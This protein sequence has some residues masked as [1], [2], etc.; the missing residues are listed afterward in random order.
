MVDK[1]GDKLLKIIRKAV[2][3]ASII[4]L[5]VV[6]IFL[7]F[8]KESYSALYLVPDSYS[9]YVGGDR[10]SFVYGIKCAEKEKTRYVLEIYYGDVLVNTKE[11]ELDS[12]ETLEQKAEIH[13]P[14]D[15]SFPT[16][17]TLI[18]RVNNNTEEVHFWL[19]G[20]K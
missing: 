20:R 8:G 13:L 11:F 9:N 6:A 7:I 16:K 15:I 5:V 12:G 1:E 4:G 18:L 10:V 3:I 2:I 14:S 17:I 19:K